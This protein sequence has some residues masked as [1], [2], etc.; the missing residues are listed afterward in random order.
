MNCG[1]IYIHASINRCRL[2]GLALVYARPSPRCGAP[3]HSKRRTC[4][5]PSTFEGLGVRPSS[6]PLLTQLA[7]Q[8]AVHTS[9]HVQYHHGAL[10]RDNWL[11]GEVVGDKRVST[12]IKSLGCME[13]FAWENSIWSSR[14]DL[15][16]EDSLV[17]RFS[18]FIGSFE[19]P[20]R[21]NTRDGR[22]LGTRS[23]PK[24]LLRN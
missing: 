16:D 21:P 1:L 5:L 17:R 6:C 19:L 14:R 10:E 8:R 11:A 18:S 23:T 22:K 3:S 9:Q 12:P 7:V 24:W 15:P 13:V 4:C 2:S 20:G